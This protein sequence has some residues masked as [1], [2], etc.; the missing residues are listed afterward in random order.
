MRVEYEL[1]EWE[2]QGTTCSVEI[3]PE[4]YRG[5]SIEEIQ[6][7]VYREIKRDAESHLHLVYAEGEVAQEIIEC[8]ANAQQLVEAD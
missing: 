5:M 1:D 8:N 4:D 2:W 3:D 6:V 7:A